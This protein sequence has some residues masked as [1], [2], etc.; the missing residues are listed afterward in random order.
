MR[1]AKSNGLDV[2]VL[3]IDDEPQIRRVM[4]NALDEIVAHVLEASTAAAGLDLA[5]SAEPEEP[6][7][8]DIGGRGIVYFIPISAGSRPLRAACF[9]RSCT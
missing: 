7:I 9:D 1:S 8:F 3:V 2:T 5:A 6:F 4:G